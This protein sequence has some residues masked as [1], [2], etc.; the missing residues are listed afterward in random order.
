M[1]NLLLTKMGWNLMKGEINW[2]NIMRAK[3]LGNLIFSHCTWR[4]D[5]PMGSK[6]WCNIVKIRTILK[7]GVR[8]LLGNG[9]QINFWEDPWLIDKPLSKKKVWVS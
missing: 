4:N 2:C 7:E 8:W 3:Y 9:N 5:L 6:I 1:N